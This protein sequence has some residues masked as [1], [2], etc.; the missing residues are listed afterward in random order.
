MVA[1]FHFMPKPLPKELRSRVVEGF[2]AG[3]GTMNEIAERF[4]VSASSV[5]RWARLN[6]LYEDINPKPHGG[7][8]PQKITDNDLDGVRELVNEKPDR[9]LDELTAAW[10]ERYPQRVGRSSINRA[11]IRAGFSLKKRPFAPLKGIRTR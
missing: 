9:T 7:G 3:L 5:S 11:L 4:R 6:M 1:A 8:P 10:N 2:E